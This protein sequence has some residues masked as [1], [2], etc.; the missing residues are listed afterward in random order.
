MKRFWSL[1]LMGGALV[2][3]SVAA[4]AQ[5]FMKPTGMKAIPIRVQSLRAEVE[6]V[7][8]VAVTNWT[9]E[10]QM[11]R[12]GLGSWD[13]GGVCDF[14]CPRPRDAKVT[15]FNVSGLDGR[16]VDRAIAAPRV[17]FR[18]A[19]NDPLL[20]SGLNAGNS[21]RATIYPLNTWN[22]ITIHGT[23]VQPLTGSPMGATYRLPLLGLRGA[24]TRLKELSVKVTARDKELPTVTNNYKLPSKAQNGA[25]VLS[26]GQKNYRV[27]RDLIVTF[28]PK[29]MASGASMLVTPDAK[30]EGG[31]FALAFVAD[32]PL[33]NFAMSGTG[34][35][36]TTFS[37]KVARA[38]DVVLASGVYSGDPA[39]INAQLSADGLAKVP[40]VTVQNEVASAL[41]ATQKINVLSAN[42]GANRSQITGLS[43]KYSVISAFTSWLTV[44]N[45][46]LKIYQKA[47]VSSQL[48]ALVREYWIQVGG[49]QEKGAR[50]AQIKKSTTLISNANGLNLNDELYARLG[51]A[52]NYAA[53]KGWY[54]GRQPK[55]VAEKR[56]A[57]L[58]TEMEQYRKAFFTG[59]Q[60][61][62]LYE[63]RTKMIAGYRQPHPDYAQLDQ[64]EHRFGQL[65]GSSYLDPRLAFW[66]R[67]IEA[68]KIEERTTAAEQKSDTVQ[69]VQLKEAR[70]TNSRMAYFVNGIGDPPIYVNAPSDARQVVAVMPDGQIKT[71]D[72]NR[73]EKRWEGN[74]DVPV[75]TKDG[76][77][78]IQIV[79]VNGD[80][81]RRRYA[82]PFRVDTKAPTGKGEVLF[83]PQNS[84]SGER[85]LRL[86]VEHGGDVAVV[87]A[88]LPWGEKVALMPS[89]VQS[90]TF[91]GLARVPKA[92]MGQSIK[93]TYILIDRAH[94]T[95]SIEAESVAPAPA[96]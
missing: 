35:E 62:D 75:G 69:L 88:L 51:S 71:L 11:E 29:K 9:M 96:L 10:I 73:F 26:L 44:G 60:K 6:I 22:G 94:N 5:V 93:V 86:E 2:S 83:S 80:G 28:K 1:I 89:T 57:R 33:K 34:V 68:Q 81:S 21:F 27:L 70:I 87:T 91:F 31:H 38:G 54:Y 74:Y 79:V 4:R 12:V 95:T 45:D 47:L 53:W 90:R 17:A 61:D 76:D 66:R 40:L 77:Y 50:V 82:M 84:P 39:S 63:L 32:R 30:A 24:T 85:T 48:D 14:I 8:A 20:R 3:A 16:V 18:A 49:G 64:L 58:T 72:Y 46:D 15:A 59:G 78:K 65:Y 92:Y 52:L 23:W 7:G 37:P 67:R 41:W 42:A 55:T 56:F 36:D 43:K 19:K 25:R 13:E